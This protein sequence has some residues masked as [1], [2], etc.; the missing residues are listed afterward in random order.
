M[1]QVKKYKERL[2]NEWKRQSNE[3]IKKIINNSHAK[4]SIRLNGSKEKGRD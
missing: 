3:E 4:H 1:E 2:I